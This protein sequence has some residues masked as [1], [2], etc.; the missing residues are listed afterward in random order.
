MLRIY[1]LQHGFE[2]SDSGAEEVL[3]DSLALHQFVGLDLA[4]EPVPNETTICKFRHLMERHNLGCKLFRLVNTYLSAFIQHLKNGHSRSSGNVLLKPLDSGLRRA[5][6]G[7][8]PSRR[9]QDFL[10]INDGEA[11]IKAI[12]LPVCVY[13]FVVIPAKAGIHACMDAGGKAAS[14]TGSRGGR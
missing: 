1:F 10:S 8:L 13:C 2:L 7:L 11:R 6:T 14:G 4:S 3:Y 12:R 9:I 5:A